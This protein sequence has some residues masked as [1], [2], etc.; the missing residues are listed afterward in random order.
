MNLSATIVTV[1]AGIAHSAVKN[2]MKITANAQ[3]RGV[4]RGTFRREYA[5][6]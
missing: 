3:T 4:T 2:A 5:K 6:A 1:A